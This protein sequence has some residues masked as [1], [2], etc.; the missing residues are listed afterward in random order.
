MSRPSFQRRIPPTDV[1]VVGGRFASIMN[2]I[3]LIRCTS[4]SPAT[5]VPYA[6]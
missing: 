4:R 5:P 2:I 6:R 1:A 3:P